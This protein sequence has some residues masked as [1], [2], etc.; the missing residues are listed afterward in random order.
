M[1]PVTH[2]EAQMRHCLALVMAAGSGVRLGGDLP[3]QYRDLG[4]VP[5]L[6]RSIQAFSAHPAI[7]GAQVVIAAD[8]AE[9]YAAAT[10]GMALPPPVIG[11][12]T[13]QASVRRGLEALLEEPPALVL[14]HDAARPFASRDLIDRVIAALATAEAVL[15]VVPV[16]DTLKRLDAAGAVV[17]EVPREA[18]ARAQTPQGF[19][20]AT[21]LEAHRRHEGVACTDDT[22]V[23]ALD[24]V[25][26]QT[27]LGEEENFKVT[28]EADLLRAET[29]LAGRPRRWVTGTGFDVHAFAA[30]RRLVLCGIELPHDRGLAGHSDADVALHAVTD[31]LFGAMADGDIGS[32]FP[33]SD[34]QWKDAS[35]DRFLRHAVARL[36]ARGGRLEHIDLTIIGE[37]PK[38]GPHRDAMRASLAA[39]TGLAVE[40]V[41]VK[42][43]TTER[44]GFCGRE[45]GLAAQAA[46]TVSFPA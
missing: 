35:S 27:V 42:A 37:R 18:L 20:F 22:G 29:H 38:I 1:T 14:V 9:L 7:D 23:V 11:G 24:G 4:G 41:G 31:A 16:V 46:V 3:K 10:A 33:P 40:S 5:M 26:V 12:A 21:L 39:T 25:A 6:R 17:D 13:R 34:P 45:E 30:G 2:D 8:Q 28:T 43:T 36:T 32:H 44:L 19:R 15:P